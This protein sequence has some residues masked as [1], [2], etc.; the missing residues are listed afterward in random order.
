M[1]KSHHFFLPFPLGAAAFGLAG[2]NLH[3]YTGWGSVTYWNA[4]VANTQMYGQGTFFDPRLRE[5]KY[6]VAARSRFDD[7]RHGPAG[8]TDVRVDALTGVLPATDLALANIALD[9]VEALG[10]RLDVAR[11]VTSGYLAADVPVLRGFRRLARRELDGW[12]A[13]LHARR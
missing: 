13:D 5:K 1:T 2:V 8:S 9:A 12:A 10:G 3:T 4:Y 7:L 6:P 11:L